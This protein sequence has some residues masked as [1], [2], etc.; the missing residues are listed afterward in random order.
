[1]NK[2][3][4]FITIIAI[5]LV[6]STVNSASLQVQQVSDCLWALIDSSSAVIIGRTLSPMVKADGVEVL[7]KDGMLPS[8]ISFS[9]ADIVDIVQ[10]IA[11]EAG[12]VAG[13]LSKL[14][15][16]P[17][18]ARD[19]SYSLVTYRALSARG[20][21]EGSYVL[22]GQLKFSYSRQS[23]SVSQFISDAFAARISGTIGSVTADVRISGNEIGREIRLK[24]LFVIRMDDLKSIEI[25]YPEGFSIDNTKY[26]SGVIKLGIDESAI[27]GI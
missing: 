10:S 2:K 7:G 16:N 24:G 20:Y 19:N 5:C 27:G 22:D 13:F 11:P 21:L 18:K 1:M 14:L 17:R 23:A 25:A 26:E 12:G 8:S 15:S 4:V 9:D 6:A 3:R